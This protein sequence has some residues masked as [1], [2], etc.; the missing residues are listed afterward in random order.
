MPRAESH[1]HRHADEGARA[2]LGVV[3]PGEA[4]ILLDV[5]DDDGVAQL[6]DLA[7]HPL[8]QAHLR[9]VVDLAG[10][11]AGGH[12]AQRLPLLIEQH[13]RADVG[14]D[15][16]H[17]ALE[18]GGEQILDLRDA[19]GHLDQLVE[20]AQLEDEVLESLRRGPEIL[21]HLVE[22][23]RQLADLGDLAEA[24]QACRR[25][26]R[27]R[28]LLVRGDGSLDVDRQPSDLVDQPAEDDKSQAGD[29]EGHEGRELGLGPGDE[30][31]DREESDEEQQRQQGH[32]DKDDRGRLPE[33]HRPGHETGKLHWWFCLL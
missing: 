6:G 5:V 32:Q 33:A 3:G 15:R 4:R 25:L 12:D 28:H 20:R 27:V 17:R 30:F 11:P 10:Q 29:D 14:V 13:D 22:G 16:A 23:A 7:R 24:R 19:G 26:V 18:D 2:V 1:A 31:R 8:S 9:L 21:Q